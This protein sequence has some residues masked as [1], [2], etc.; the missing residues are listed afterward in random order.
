[1]R[2][3]KSVDLKNKIKKE[4]KVAVCRVLWKVEMAADTSNTRELKL[5]SVSRSTCSKE[6]PFTEREL[7]LVSH[8]M[9]N[10]TGGIAKLLSPVRKKTKQFETRY[11][12]RLRPGSMWDVPSS[13]QRSVH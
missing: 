9:D 4:E 7:G 11:H 12:T 1:M 2:K 8:L 10:W 3:I 5:R 6:I 13:R